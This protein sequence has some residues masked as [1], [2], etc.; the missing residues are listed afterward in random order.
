MSYHKLAVI[1]E[2]GVGKTQL[3][4]TLSS[5]DPLLTEAKSSIDI[6]KKFTTV[7]I[8]YGR[9]NLDSDTALGL[10][11]VPGQE[12]FS[13]LWDFVNSNLWGLVLLIRFQ[14][15]L[16]LENM[17]HLL[18][19]FAPRENGVAC[20]VALTHCEDG[21]LEARNSAAKKIQARLN[22]HG[23]ISPVLFVDARQRESAESI[24]H[25]LNAINRFH[26]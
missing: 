19:F 11:G 22:N 14:A 17:D 26:N 23:L 4:N 9:I 1:G 12:R 10:Y 20:L 8:E 6:G 16:H 25:A 21:N 2:V 24:L 7:G 3:I 13:F 15:E 5:I 18:E